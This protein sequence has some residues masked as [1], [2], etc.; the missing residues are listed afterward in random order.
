M[1]LLY[2]DLVSTLEAK[3]QSKKEFNCIAIRP[4]I[5][6]LGAI[7]GD[8]KISVYDETGNTLISESNTVD[9]S[10][11]SSATYFH[12]VVRFDINVGFKRD[13]SYIV[14]LEGTGAYSPSDTIHVGWCRDFDLR[15]FD[16]NYLQNV[17]YN[18][19]FLFEVWT[20]DARIR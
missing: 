13:T 6:K 20:N 2:N 10:S 11:I 5:L 16:A 18:S 9:I 1:K 14:R 7:T 15:K 17:G 4:H 3:V 8:L 19:A 12:G